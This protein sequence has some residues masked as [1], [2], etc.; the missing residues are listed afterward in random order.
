VWHQSSPPHLKEAK[1]HSKGRQGPDCSLVREIIAA[2][3]TSGKALEAKAAAARQLAQITESA[4][5]DE[6]TEAPPALTKRERKAVQ[7]AM[8]WY[9]LMEV[10]DED[11]VELCV[12]LGLITR[13]EYEQHMRGITEGPPRPYRPPEA[14][15]LL[16]PPGKA[17]LA[18]LAL[19]A[20]L[21]ENGDAQRGGLF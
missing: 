11:Q 1:V 16:A 5:Q 3:G 18:A 9:P 7:E 8:H 13:E 21:D 12:R 2:P 10:W 17:A 19:G 15:S 6:P 14:R 20:P 4:V